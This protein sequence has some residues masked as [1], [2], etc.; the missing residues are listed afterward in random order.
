VSKESRNLSSSLRIGSSIRQFLAALC[1]G[2]VLCASEG[3]NRPDA[4]NAEASPPP[5]VPQVHVG[6]PEPHTIHRMVDQP[7]RIEAFEQTPIFAKIAG[8]VQKVNVE[9]GSRVRKGELLAELWVPEIVEQVRQK[10][11]QVTQ[12]KIA[13]DQAEKTLAVTRASVETARSL[14]NEAIASRKRAASAFDRWKSESERMSELVRKKVIDAETGDETANQFRVAAATLEE[15]GAKIASAEAAIREA[16]AKRDKAASD[17]AAARN[18][19]E[20]TEADLWQTQAMLDYAR[21][22]APFDG[23][24]SERHVDTGHFLQ[25]GTSGGGVRSEPLFVVVRMDRVRVFLEVPEADAVLVSDGAAGCIRVPVLNDQEFAGRV[26][27]SSWSLDPAQRTLRAEI[28]FDNSKG[29]LRPG[30][31]AHAIVD[32]TQSA[33]L[34]L[35]TQAVLTRDGQTFCYRVED[36]KALRMQVRIGV[37]EGTRLELMKKQVPPAEP[38]GKPRWENFTGDELIVLS[39]PGELT[40]G[41]EVNADQAISAIR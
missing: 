14:L 9:I 20:M 24:V 2:V 30:M 8:Y 22:P 11:T 21:I 7:A 4:A 17:V 32:V 16:E 19:Q 39:N 25:P 10:K 5:A 18:H 34:T 31:Y 12:A 36:G 41:Q 13:I 1:G 23:V 37:R 28:D 3:C 38:G 35:P 33:A 26:A 6:R 40:D 29:N 15:A 27:G